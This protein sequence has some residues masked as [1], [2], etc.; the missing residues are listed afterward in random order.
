MTSTDTA[1]ESA[2]AHPQAPRERTLFRGKWWF[3]GPVVP[4]I[5]LDLWSKAAAFAYVGDKPGQRVEFDFLP[6]PF[7]FALVKFENTG[8]IWGLGQEL[9]VPLMV[10]RCVALFVIL[11]FVSGT[12]VVQRFQQLVLGLIFAGAIG[13]LYD[14]FFMEERGVRDFLLFYYRGANGAVT[15]WPAFNVADS[16]ISVGAVLLLILLWRDPGRDAKAKASG[17]AGKG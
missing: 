1:K 3:W 10:L 17:G 9:T 2:T 16:C 5:A 6:D 15:A 14:N 4:L 8:T 11:W 13:N 12:R 7:G